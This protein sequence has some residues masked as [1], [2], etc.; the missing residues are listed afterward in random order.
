MT[1]LVSLGVIQK[2]KHG[3]LGDFCPGSSQHCGRGGGPAGGGLASAGL[4]SE[5]VQLL[6]NQTSARLDTLS[7]CTGLVEKQ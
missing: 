7:L 4:W 3:V 1:R 2:S 6:P 5:G